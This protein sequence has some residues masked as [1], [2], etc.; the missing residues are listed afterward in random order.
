M[1]SLPTQR[2]R[3]PLLKRG[4]FITVDYY[5]HDDEDLSSWIEDNTDDGIRVKV[6]DYDEDAE[7]IWIENCPYAIPSWICYK[8]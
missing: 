6:I 3:S 5:K 8:D 4:Q 2:G 1:I 7:L